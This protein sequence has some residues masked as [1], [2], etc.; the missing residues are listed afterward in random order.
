MLASGVSSGTLEKR[1]SNDEKTRTK[2]QGVGR[3][4]GRGAGKI[5]K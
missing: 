5:K 3:G 2:N 1:L 4:R